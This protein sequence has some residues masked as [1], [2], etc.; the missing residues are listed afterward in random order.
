MQLPVMIATA[1]NIDAIHFVYLVKSYFHG[2]QTRIQANAQLAGIAGWES[3]FYTNKIDLIY[4]L[5]E[6]TRK[7]G[8]S[9]HAAAVQQITDM[10][11]AI[12]TRAGIIHHLEQYLAGNISQGDLK[13]WATWHQADDYSHTA[14]LYDYSIAFCCL[15]LLPVHYHQL[16]SKNYLQLLQLFKK[17]GG[18]PEKELKAMIRLFD[19][20]ERA[21]HFFIKDLYTSLLKALR[22]T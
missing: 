18:D 22:E 11:D 2:T 16:T 8:R 20:E 13:E 10:R 17:N 12:P 14:L 6:A 7:K 21:L 4:A 3:G 19:V 15:G 5:V 1:E 9:F